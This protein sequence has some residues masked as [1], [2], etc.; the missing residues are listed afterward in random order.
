MGCMVWVGRSGC[1]VRVAQSR[2]NGPGGK[3]PVLRPCCTV[4]VA[5][6]RLYDGPVARSRQHGLGCLVPVS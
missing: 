1:T 3:V 6:S 4:W 2:L 5:W